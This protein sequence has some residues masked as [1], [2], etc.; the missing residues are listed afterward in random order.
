MAFQLPDSIAIK[1][2]LRR[3]LRP[4]TKLGKTTLWFGGLALLLELSR[5]ITRSPSGTMLS[6]WANFIL[7]VFL[8]C[9]LILGWRW[10]R[11]KLM[12]RLRNR[13][14]VTYVFIGVIPVILLVSMALLAGYLFAGQFATYVASADLQSEL[15]HLESA[16]RSLA[17]QLRSLAN[18][19]GLSEQVASE[20]ARAS[21]ENFRQRTVTIWEDDRG[22]VVP[23]DR[24]GEEAQP[25]KAPAE[26]KGDFSGIVLDGRRL[27]L[28]V[29]KRF[30]EGTRHLIVISN[31]PVTAQLLRGAA[32]Q[33]GSVTILP[34]ESDSD[35]TP[36]VQAPA[37]VPQPSAVTTRP[38]PAGKPAKR[39]SERNTVT[40]AQSRVN[41]SSEGGRVGAGQVPPPANSLDFQFPFATRF[42][43]VDWQTGKTL[44]G[45]MLVDTRPSMVYATLFSTLGE[46]SRIFLDVLTG[47]AI[48]FGLIE[49]VALVIGVRL[50][51]S[52]TKS[53]AELY[54]ATGHINR[55]DLG[56]RIQV[57][58]SDQMAALEQSF[59]SMT[60]SLSKLIAE[61]KEKQRLEG[62]LA[63]AHEVQELLF[64]ADLS[65][66][67]S[68]EV[69]GTCRPARTVS[70]DYYDFI[71]L[72]QDKLILA[73]GD[74]S[75]KGIS[76]A[77]L[78]ATVHAF[79]RA[80]SLEPE[81]TLES[82]AVGAGV[83]DRS[84]LPM[85]SRSNGNGDSGLSP[86]VLMSTLNYQLYRSTPIEKYATM[87]LGRYDAD[88][89]ALT[90]SN[91][92][93]LP[94]LVLGGNDRITRLETSGTVVGLF[95]GMSYEE[96][97]VHMEPGD[98]FVAY[99]DG[100]TEPENEFGEF[101]EERLIELIQRH[102][103]Q[104]LA[105]ISDIV[106]G[107]V[108]DWIAGGEQPDDVTL[109]LARAR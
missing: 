80:Y 90:Y 70:G 16:N 66:L 48:F 22:F 14:I 50:T 2:W 47:I 1:A 19:G 38:S 59:N 15:Q 42:N 58:T 13:L 46:K 79:V 40:I 53:V 49:L 73:V 76:A 27:H 52:I 93:H 109:V 33:L 34:P 26:I 97:S 67:P 64:P 65:G 108:A 78:M 101:G 29:I 84:G 98:I 104:P 89:C 44:S 24:R 17:V 23:P 82:V 8:N 91:A 106:T 68:L 18:T 20:I 105:R 25:I 51:R 5:L 107:A 12:W 69:H 72:R 63:I 77:L 60:E 94:P 75:G 57:R 88:S 30:D 81:L 100:I 6:G 99:S 10:L 96:S 36:A 95:D 92:G 41:V 32:S 9:A 61:Q 39:A 102:R 37:A 103:D 7:I 35:E 43:A 74:I 31:A 86:A 83:S 4:K 11:R 21:A 28:R 3:V 85:Y 87:F 56:H 55:G 62:E 71:P 45:L 54:N